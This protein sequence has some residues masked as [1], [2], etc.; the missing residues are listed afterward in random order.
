[1]IRPTGDL[2]PD[3]E[4]DADITRNMDM[5]AARCEAMEGV[6]KVIDWMDYQCTPPLSPEGDESPM[7]HLIELE[8]CC[9]KVTVSPMVQ[10]PTYS[11]KMK[12]LDMD[13]LNCPMLL[14]VTATANC[15]FSSGLTAC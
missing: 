3:Q 10:L 15:S 14:V 6:D 1:M 12:Y 13:F 7:L 11:F 5:A 4:E 8:A 9:R 2:V